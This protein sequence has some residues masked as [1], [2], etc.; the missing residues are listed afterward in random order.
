MKPSQFKKKVRYLDNLIARYK[1][2]GAIEFIK[3]KRNELLNTNRG[4]NFMRQ[5]YNVKLRKDRK[6]V[7]EVHEIIQN[8]NNHTDN[9]KV[10]ANIPTAVNQHKTICKP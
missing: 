7:E 3:F 9:P 2:L 4:F 1:N 5:D 10:S 6:T 8:I